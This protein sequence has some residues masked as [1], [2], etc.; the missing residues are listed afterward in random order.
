MTKE[1]YQK[2]LNLLL[3]AYRKLNEAIENFDEAVTDKKMGGILTEGG[4][5]LENKFTNMLCQTGCYGMIQKTIGELVAFYH[6]DDLSNRQ[7]AE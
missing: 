7:S 3:D 2:N 5:E 1:E 4:L 6:C